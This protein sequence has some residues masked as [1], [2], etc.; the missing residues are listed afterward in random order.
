M[1]EERPTL[2]HGPSIPI[3][4]IQF[5]AE[6][7]VGRNSEMCEICQIFFGSR[8]LG[9]LKLI[10]DLSLHQIIVLK[11]KRNSFEFS[12]PWL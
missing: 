9:V 1:K 2:S 4:T 11:D 3:L 8:G 7:V 12:K 6:T 10:Y 5:Q